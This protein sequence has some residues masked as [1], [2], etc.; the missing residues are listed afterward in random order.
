MAGKLLPVTVLDAS[1]VQKLWPAGH[2][3]VHVDQKQTGQ[4]V[5]SIT[6]VQLSSDHGKSRKSPRQIQM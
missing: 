2:L 4:I 3:L 1:V 6:N 5:G